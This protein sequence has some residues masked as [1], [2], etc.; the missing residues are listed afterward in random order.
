MDKQNPYVPPPVQEAVD[1]QP[2]PAPKERPL[3]RWLA[4]FVAVCLLPAIVATDFR[5]FEL[6]MIGFLIMSLYGAFAFG[7]V[8]VAGRWPSFK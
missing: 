5:R 8:A 2:D 3:V 7:F 4:A 1:T 6:S